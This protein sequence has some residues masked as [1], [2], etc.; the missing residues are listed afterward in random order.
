M[1]ALLAAQVNAVRLSEDDLLGFCF[2][3]SSPATTTTTLIGNGVE[4]LAR[5][6]DQR[7]GSPPTPPSSRPPSR[8]CSA[9]S[10]RPRPSPGRRSA[11][12]S[13]TVCSIPAGSRVMLLFGAANLDER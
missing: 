1:S 5:H 10:P 9:S 3:L 11:T 8:R 2:F 7:G 13:A 12:P 6:P 4:F